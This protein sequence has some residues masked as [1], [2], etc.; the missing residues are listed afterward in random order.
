MAVIMDI[1]HKNKLH[2]DNKQEVGRRLALNA[3]ANDYGKSVEWSGPVFKAMTVE[4]ATAVMSF[5]HAKGLAAKDGNLKG[6]VLAGDDGRFF[7]ATAQVQGA[8]VRVT[9]S[10]VAKPAAVRYAWANSPT[11]NLVNGAGLPASPFRFPLK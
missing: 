11:C 10:Q 1:D 4:G 8:T 7:P 6:F 5:D 3:L 9:C 2:P